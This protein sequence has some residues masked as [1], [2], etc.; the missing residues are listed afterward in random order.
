M[1]PYEQFEKLRPQKEIIAKEIDIDFDSIL[2]VGCQ[3][4]ENILALERKF[5]NKRI[6][7]VDMDTEVISEGRKYLLRGMLTYGDV[8]SLDY[9]DNEFD[10]VFTNALICM[11]EK[12]DVKQAIKEI[13]RVAK[14]QI[15]FIELMTEDL[16]GRVHGK[17]RVGVNWKQMFPKAEIRKITKE[18]WDAEP[19]LSFGYLIKLKL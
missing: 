14:K 4:G 12:S 10:I 17:G 1:T 2:E 8:R 19:W 15:M 7:G 13:K 11:L 6:L 9:K 3:W 18:E 5:P 16:I